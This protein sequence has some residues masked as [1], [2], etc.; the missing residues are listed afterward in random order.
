MVE[1]EP[2]QRVGTAF[3]EPGQ[4]TGRTVKPLIS[5]L[6]PQLAGV[7]EVH[8]PRVMRVGPVVEVTGIPRMPEAQQ[9]LVKETREAKVVPVA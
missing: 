4:I 6:Y 2:A 3:S 5:V 7:V 9:P 1:E 8:M